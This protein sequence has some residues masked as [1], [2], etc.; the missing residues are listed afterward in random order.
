MVGIYEQWALGNFEE[1]KRLQDSIRP[2][3]NCF[4]YGNANTIVKIAANMLGNNVGPCRKPFCRLS[5]EGM[6]QLKAVLDECKAKGM[7]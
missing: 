4:R 2:F 3:R 6:R 7:D 5:D 1:A